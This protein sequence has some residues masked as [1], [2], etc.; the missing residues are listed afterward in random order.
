MKKFNLSEQELVS[1]MEKFMDDLL[2]KDNPCRY[3]SDFRTLMI[4][5]WVRLLEKEKK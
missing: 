2:D 5:K 4:V 1:F 3:S